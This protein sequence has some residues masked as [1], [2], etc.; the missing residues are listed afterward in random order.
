[1][2]LKVALL[3]ILAAI[4]LIVP[5]AAHATQQPAWQRALATRSDALDRKY[6]L[7][8]YAVP[9]AVT[10]RTSPAWYRALELR[11]EALNERYGLR[12]FAAGSTGEAFDWTAAGI[13]AALAT[14]VCVLLAA[15][16]LTARARLVAGTQRL[17]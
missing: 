1:M 3:G 15:A 13:G 14:G 5:V 7:G 17:S 9:R 12:G 6:H 2:H 16:A 10:A 11:S 4:A 8:R